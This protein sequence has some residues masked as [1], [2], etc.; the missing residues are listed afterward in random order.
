M[1]DRILSTG[2]Q[3]LNVLGIAE[4]EMQAGMR[5]RAH[6]HVSTAIA[7]QLTACSVEHQRA[8]GRV[9]TLT[10]EVQQLKQQLQAKG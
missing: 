9:N 5:E 10:A 3:P 7:E 6:A 4:Q 2:V 8:L 1:H